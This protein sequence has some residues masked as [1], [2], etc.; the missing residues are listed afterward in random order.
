MVLSLIIIFHQ[1]K[2]IYYI[3]SRS[4]G[5]VKYVDGVAMNM[6]R[7]LF[8]KNQLNACDTL[9]RSGHGCLNC[10]K[11]GRGHAKP[12]SQAMMW[13]PKSCPNKHHKTNK[14][15]LLLYC[16]SS[17]WNFCAYQSHILEKIIQTHQINGNMF[18]QNHTD[19]TILMNRSIH[20]DKIVF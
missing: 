20:H 8:M 3:F 10:L 16:Q 14:N 4:V 6:P 7:E 15:C 18:G 9:H 5:T 12:R 19:L 1:L 11:G 13:Q 17:K 2:H